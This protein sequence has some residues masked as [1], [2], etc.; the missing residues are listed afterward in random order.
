MRRLYKMPPREKID[1]HELAWAAG[2]FD[3]EGHVAAKRG[4]RKHD[5]QRLVYRVVILDIRQKDRRVLDRFVKAVGA[6]KVY[7]PYRKNKISD[8][9][10]FCYML[11]SFYKVEK[12][13]R[14]LW[15]WL[16]PIKRAQA[17]TAIHNWR[18]EPR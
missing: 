15:P 10:Y 8:F 14:L 3:G 18:N 9:R 17:S 7:G 16:S 1:T 4:K 12:V 2:L 13:I 5:P 11:C 6:G